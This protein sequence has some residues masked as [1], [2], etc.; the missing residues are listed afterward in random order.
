MVRSTILQ[1]ATQFNIA[2]SRRFACRLSATSAAPCELD[3]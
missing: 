3:G 1:R 2:Q